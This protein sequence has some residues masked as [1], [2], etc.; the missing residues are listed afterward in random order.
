MVQPRGRERELSILGAV[1]ELLGENGYERLA[2]DAVAARARTSKTTIYSRWPDKATLVAAALNARSGDLPRLV[3]KGLDLRSDLLDLV[4]LFTRMGQTESMTVF[5]SVLIAS[6]GE[7]VL[8]DAFHGTALEPRRQDCAEIVARAIARG[9]AVD[10]AAAAELFDL[11]MGKTLVRQV[12]ERRPL[13][14]TE[15]AAF[16]DSVLIPTLV[17]SE[18]H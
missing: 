6:E 7:P 5:M 4:A 11:V 18:P 12:I 16:V 14:S 9:E 15:Q 3:P 1:L 2:I 17:T 8:A 10:R 13:T